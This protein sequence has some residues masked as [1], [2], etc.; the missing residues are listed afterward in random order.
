M[1][2]PFFLRC[3]LTGYMLALAASAVAAEAANS[4]SGDERSLLAMRSLDQRVATIGHRLATAGVD[5]CV[6][7]QWLPGFALHDA[8]QYGAGYRESAIRTFGLQYGPGVL[9]LAADGPAERAGLATDDV[10]LAVDGQSLPKNEE[11]RAGSFAVVESILTAV[12]RE[13]ADGAADLD[14]RRG[15]EALTI[16]IEG[17]QGCASRFQ[18]IPSRELNARADGR[19]VQITTAIGDYVQ[20]DAELAA[21][22]AHEFAHN[23]LQHKRR[24]DAARISRGLFSNF[25]RSARLIRET[26][27]EAD[28]LSVYLLEKAGYDPEAAVRFWTRFGPRGLNLFVDPTHPHWRRRVSVL[29]EENANILRQKQMGER[30]MP[31]FLEAAA[32]PGRENPD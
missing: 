17:E 22:L 1:I 32:E 14:I 3:L 2:K 29:R 7:R 28:R 11:A 16:R 5:Y 27:T 6:E 31:A 15:E 18:L 23:V 24:L 9:A 12:E 21:V 10:I 19:Y 20:D 30:L 4:Q 8:S 25:G 13:F 26:E